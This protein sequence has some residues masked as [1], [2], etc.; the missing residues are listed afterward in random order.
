MVE[1]GAAVKLT[2]EMID[3]WRGPVWYVSHMV[4]PNPHS[5]TTPARR[6]WNSSQQFRGVSMNDLLLKGPDVVNPI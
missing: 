6:V 4:A 3:G 1:R 5:V 2:T